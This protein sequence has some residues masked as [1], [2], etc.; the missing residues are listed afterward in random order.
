V[1]LSALSACLLA[2]AADPAVKLASPGLKAVGVPKDVADFYSD[3]LA[4][5]LTLKGFRVITPSEISSLLGLERQKALLG[6]T[7]QSSD[8]MAELGDALG[9]DG[10]I[11]GSIGKFGDAYQINIKIISARDGRPLSVF[12]VRATGETDVLDGL[13]RAAVHMA[14]E[15]YA[16]LKR[17]PP[18]GIVFQ[19]EEEPNTRRKWAWVP[20]T[21]GVVSAGVATYLLL[22]A[23]SFENELVSNV[24]APPLARAQ[25]DRSQGPV[26]QGVGI[27]LL[28]AGAVGLGV[29]GW[30][31]ASGGTGAS[32]A[33]M[34]TGTGVSVAGMF[35]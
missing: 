10:V 27:A 20:A 3:D 6:C 26:Y 33:V 22:Q 18:P 31:F 12:S 7:D 21:A 17:M 30:M 1:L 9:V 35:P 19:K 34:P 8:C 14:P 5:A 25:Q 24:P 16:G 32:V 11:T 23:K 4:Q 28:A 29:G 13:N 15:A 2:A